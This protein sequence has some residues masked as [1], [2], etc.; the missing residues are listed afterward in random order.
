MPGRFKAGQSGNPA[1]RPK[2]ALS[3]AMKLIKQASPAVLQ[4][5]IAQAIDGD[6]QAAALVLARGVPTLKATQ[7]PVELITAAEFEQMTTPERAEAILA[8]AVSGRIAPDV[9]QQLITS[10]TAVAGVTEWAELAQRVEEL[11]ALK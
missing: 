2:G 8:A 4:Q 10:L 5:V 11:E 6:M 9:A 7:E 1:G 3:P